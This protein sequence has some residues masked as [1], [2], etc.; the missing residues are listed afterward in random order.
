MEAVLFSLLFSMVL[1]LGETEIRID[2]QK[3]MLTF[4]IAEAIRTPLFGR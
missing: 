3:K 1:D 4:L 2:G